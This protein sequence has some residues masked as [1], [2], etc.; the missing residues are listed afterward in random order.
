MLSLKSTKINT[1]RPG[2]LRLASFG[3]VHLHHA[4][5]PTRTILRNL[6]RYLTNDAVLS[7]L[8]LLICTGDL[9]DN[10]L[11]NASE[12]LDWIN[13][14]MTRVL[15]KC[16]EHDV[17]F[18]IVEGT[19]SHDW[20]Q[21]RFLL[22]Q[23]QNAQIPVDVHYATQL[24]VEY[25]ER[26]DCHILY[27]PD[28]W[29]TDTAET[30]EDVRV[31]LR[32]ENLEQ[33]DF[34]VMHGAF[35]YQLPAIVKEPAHDEDAYHDLVRSLIFIGHVHLVNPHR[36]ILPA[37]S[38]DRL[39]HNEEGAKGYFDVT[40]RGPTDYDVTFVENT[41]AKLYVTLDVT[42]TTIEAAWKRITKKA[43]TLPQGS[44][45]RLKC[46]KSHPIL[47]DM[48]VLKHQFDHLEWSTP[49]VEGTTATVQ[50]DEL[51]SLIVDISHLPDITADTVQDLIGP[52]VDRHLPDPAQRSDCLA[53]LQEVITS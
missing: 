38:F 7:Q 3:D 1:K 52:Y 10:L 12:E 28:K 34:A 4:N 22:E 8:D 20:Q 6:D 51:E 30:L 5:T 36:R 35:T 50:S 17:V 26:F 21:S 24:S 23:A 19:P 44:A 9:F 39:A 47:A 25:I 45:L 46:G 18:R 40:L 15:Y 31:L 49:K 37:G 41:T 33:V 29:R 13:R 53:R 42:D 11:D 43:K 14:W 32:K 2:Q 48:A 16:A 27:V